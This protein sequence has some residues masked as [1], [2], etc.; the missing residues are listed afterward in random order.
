MPIYEYE[1][2]QCHHRFETLVLHRQEQVHC[3]ACDGTALNKLMSA[4][5]V[6]SGRAEPACATPACGAGACPACQ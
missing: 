2:G 6:G 3:P 5:A 1:C 4:H